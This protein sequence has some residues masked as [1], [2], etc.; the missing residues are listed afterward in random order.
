MLNSLLV[1]GVVAN[2]LPRKG[3]PGAGASEGPVRGRLPAS[4]MQAARVS[5]SLSCHGSG[6]AWGMMKKNLSGSVGPEIVVSLCTVGTAPGR[7]GR[8]CSM[9]H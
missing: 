8:V 2:S 3:G 5:F 7:P 1:R 6:R 4:W 9:V